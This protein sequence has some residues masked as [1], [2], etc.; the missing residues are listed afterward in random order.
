MAQVDRHGRTT[1][2]MESFHRRSWAELPQAGL[3]F[4]RK[5]FGMHHLPSDPSHTRR[6]GSAS[7]RCMAT[8][9]RPITVSQNRTCCDESCLQ[10]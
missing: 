5:H 4:R 8:A 3:L 6:S 10:R 9:G 2:E 7:H 1:D